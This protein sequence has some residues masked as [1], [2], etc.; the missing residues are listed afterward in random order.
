MNRDDT[1]SLRDTVILAVMALAIDRPTIKFVVDE[2]GRDG[3]LV[4]GP[5]K[6][7]RG[8]IG[9]GP[10]NRRALLQALRWLRKISAL[11]QKP[12]G[13]GRPPADDF[14]IMVMIATVTKP[15]EKLADF[16][17]AT[18]IVDFYNLD[19]EPKSIARRV[20]NFLHPERKKKSKKK[21]P[22]KIRRLGKSSRNFPELLW[23]SQIIIVRT[24]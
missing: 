3:K 24:F 14:E 19:T 1:E 11:R 21:K 22:R 23:L 6:K 4:Y 18:R 15:G 12:R 8:Q 2:T 7:D 20:T 13:R 10:Y 17:I 9:Y 16:K 5:T